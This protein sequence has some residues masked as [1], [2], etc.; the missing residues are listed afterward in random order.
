MLDNENIACCSN[1]I[2]S[3]YSPNSSTN[4][5]IYPVLTNSS[6]YLATTTSLHSL[7]L[8]HQLCWVLSNSHRRHVHSMARCMWNPFSPVWTEHTGCPRRPGEARGARRIR[9]IVNHIRISFPRGKIYHYDLDIT[10]PLRAS[11]PSAGAP[12]GPVPGQKEK[13]LPKR[14]RWYYSHSLLVP[15]PALWCNFSHLVYWNAKQLSTHS[16]DVAGQHFVPGCAITRNQVRPATASCAG[17]I[18]FSTAAER[19]TVASNCPRL[20]ALHKYIFLY[21]SMANPTNRWEREEQR[22]KAPGGPW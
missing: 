14:I 21:F 15:F 1:S 5:L 22:E 17:R 2:V 19:S 8:W 3:M 7:I 12:G 20:I 18:S 9:V 13:A 11:K 16:C 10:F 4:S 6:T